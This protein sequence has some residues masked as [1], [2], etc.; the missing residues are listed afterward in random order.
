MRK[1]TV[2]VPFI[3]GTGP[4]IQENQIGR[5]AGWGRGE[6]S[7][8]AGSFKK[9]KVKETRQE[10]DQTDYIKSAERTLAHKQRYAQAE[11][12]GGSGRRWSG[13]GRRH[14]VGRWQAVSRWLT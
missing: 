1:P 5:G 10:A 6:I 7:G 9:K 12:T 2:P 4:P 8:V 14:V 3:E 13:Q 11:R